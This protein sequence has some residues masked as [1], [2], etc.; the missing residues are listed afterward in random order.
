MQEAKQAWGKGTKTKHRACLCLPPSLGKREC[1]NRKAASSGGHGAETCHLPLVLVE[2]ALVNTKG[3]HE[4]PKAVI[5]GEQK[6]YLTIILISY[7]NECLC[8][9][10]HHT[11]PTDIYYAT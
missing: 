5:V 11:V 4:V 2:G 7:I 3:Q 10:K 8:L 1:S 6:C 9:L